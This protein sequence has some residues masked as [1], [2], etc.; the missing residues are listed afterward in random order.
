[1]LVLRTSFLLD[2]FLLPDYF[3][4]SVF[5]LE[6]ELGVLFEGRM[7]IYLFDPST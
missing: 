7:T 2:M 1:M 4:W 5:S 3:L 6:K